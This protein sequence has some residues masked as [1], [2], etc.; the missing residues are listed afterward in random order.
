MLVAFTSSL[1]SALDA[2]LVVGAALAFARAAGLRHLVPAIGGGVAAAVLVSAAGASWLSRVGDQ[3]VWEQRLAIAAAAAIAALG[4]V[5][6]TRRRH[7]AR[8]PRH[9][10]RA[11]GVERLVVWAVTVVVLGREGVHIVLAVA[12][13]VLQVR[14]AA[15]RA[16]VIAG[17][18]AGAAMA[19]AWARYAPRLPAPW[20]ARA[21][22]VVMVLAWGLVLRELASGTVWAP[23]PASGPDGGG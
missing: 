16:G 14:I 20:F 19:W 2:F 13:F 18:V 1:S 15:L 7:L 22:G 5:M 21:T 17:L 11:T 23:D 10:V 4:A 6:W 12:P 8:V 9:D 3:L